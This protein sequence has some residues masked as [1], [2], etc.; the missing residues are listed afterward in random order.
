MNLDINKKVYKK[1]KRNSLYIA[2]WFLIFI[3]SL[4]AWLY[5]Y[6]TFLENKNNNTRESIVKKEQS[7]KNLESIPKIIASSLYNANKWAITQMWY[8]SEITSF[9]NHIYDLKRKYNIQFKWFN[10]S[11]WHLSTQVIATSDWFWINY[12]KIVRFIEQYRLNKDKSALFDLWL[13]RSVTTVNDWVDKVFNINLYL[14]D[15]ISQIFK[16]IEIEKEKIEIEKEKIEKNKQLIKDKIQEQIQE[17][18]ELE[19]KVQ[20]QEEPIL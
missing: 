14:K 9:I 6:N 15:D 5:F 13:V 8:R 1:K 20:E 12:E 19:D 7:I 16:Q 17:Q 11:N 3:I 18:E 4:T 2:S 10:Y